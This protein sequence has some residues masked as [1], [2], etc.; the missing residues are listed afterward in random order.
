MPLRLAL[1]NALQA[2]KEACCM[3]HNIV[4][5]YDN[6]AWLDRLSAEWSKY[7]GCLTYTPTSREAVNV[8]GSK[9]YHLIILS[10][11]YIKEQLLPSIKMI[12]EVTI[13]PILV[14]ADDYNVV[15]MCASIRSGADGYALTTSTME[16]LVVLGFSHIRRYSYF[17]CERFNKDTVAYCG[18]HLDIHLRVV[19]I[20]DIDA[21]LT[22]GEF[23]CLRMLIS[24][25]G[26]TF[27]YDQLYY[28]SFGEKATTGYIESSIHS[29]IK[30]L[31]RKIG[32]EHSTYIVSVHGIGYKMDAKC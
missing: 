31:R 12:R 19:K 6:V 11:D 1:A 15:D 24:Q 3:L 30:R 18:I 4:C 27:N 13:M 16:E 20:G 10:S 22:R 7:G 23:E 14:V 26:R 25:P 5:I 32:P 9:E 28:G 29:L 17:D 8:L 21:T 2:K